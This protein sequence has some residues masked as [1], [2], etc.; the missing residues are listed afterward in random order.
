MKGIANGTAL[1][2]WIPVIGG[3]YEFGVSGSICTSESDCTYKE[4]GSVE[5]K[6]ELTDFFSATSSVG[7]EG[8]WKPSQCTCAYVFNQ[9]A[10]SFTLSGSGSLLKVVIFWPPGVKTTISPVLTGSASAALN[11]NALAGAE[12]PSWPPTGGSGTFTLGGGV[13]VEVELLAGLLKG[14]GTGLANVTTSANFPPKAA[15]ECAVSIGHWCYEGY[16]FEL[17]LT[18]EAGWGILKATHTKKWGPTCSP[19]PSP[20]A[21][22]D[23][24]SDIA[25]DMDSVTI[26]RFLLSGEDNPVEIYEESVYTLEALTGTGSVYEGISVLADI[27]TD[28]LNDGAPAAAISGSGEMLVVWTKDHAAA[29]LGATV[30]ATTW[31]GTAW[32]TPVPVSDSVEFHKDPAV[33]FDSSGNPMVIWSRALNDGLIGRRRQWRK[34]WRRSKPQTLSTRNESL[35]CGRARRRCRRSPA[36][37]SRPRSP[38]DPPVRS[39]L[40][41]LTSRRACGRSTPRSGTAARGRR[42]RSSRQRLARSSPR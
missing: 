22:L 41:G 14:T 10:V 5:A 39:P 11:W 23:S 2:Q 36:G 18:I 15:N 29:Q 35:A 17:T 9:G 38:L 21:A 34:S 12:F 25:S 30:Q 31:G 16:C 24:Y 26:E 28:F 19:P 33:V 20:I 27:S 6:V 4:S 32:D 7:I 42:R 37:T 13:S 1:P 40:R 8:T 3:K